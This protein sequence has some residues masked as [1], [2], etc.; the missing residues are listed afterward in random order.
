GRT[1]F[2]LIGAYGSPELASQAIELN[3]YQ[4]LSDKEKKYPLDYAVR[5]NEPVALL[6]ANA[7]ARHHDSLPQLAATYG[8]TKLMDYLS[9]RYKESD[10]KEYEQKPEVASFLVAIARDNRQEY[11]SLLEHSLDLSDTLYGESLLSIAARCNN[12]Q[13]F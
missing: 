3:Q 1:P 5:M 7:D 2:H 4:Q 12:L 8:Q 10:T 11:E 9:K 13:A 6:L